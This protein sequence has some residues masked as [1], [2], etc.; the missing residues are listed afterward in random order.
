MTEQRV[1]CV[2]APLDLMVM[3]IKELLQGSVMKLIM[4]SNC[5]ENERPNSSLSQ[6][7]TVV[8]TLT[9]AR[10]IPASTEPPVRMG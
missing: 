10:A 2:S 5:T 8:T 4:S 7:P 1:G 6:A 3:I 9:T